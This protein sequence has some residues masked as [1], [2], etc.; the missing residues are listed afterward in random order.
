MT[1]AQFRTIRTAAG[2]T[3]PQLASLLGYHHSPHGSVPLS[4]IEHGHRP[5]TQRTAMLM[6]LLEAEGIA[7][8]EWL[9]ITA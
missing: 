1:P 3:Q 8:L 5:I 4:R 7:A 9:K 6:R 2:L